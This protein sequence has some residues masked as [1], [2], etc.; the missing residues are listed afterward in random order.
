M[1]QSSLI[2]SAARTTTPRPI[3]ARER[4]AGAQA[5]VLAAAQASL[6][7]SVPSALAVV[8]ETEGSVYA[9]QGTLA[10]FGAGQQTGWISGGCLEPALLACAEQAM[11]TDTLQLL[12]IDNLDD[13]A[14][15]SGGSTGCRGRQVVAIF[16]L[17]A[18]PFMDA[19][20]TTWRKQGVSL[21]LTVTTSGLVHMACGNYVSQQVLFPVLPDTLHT[22]SR[23][24]V[25]IPT[26]PRV[27]LLG[28]GPEAV[29]LLRMLQELG[30][31]C[32]CREPRATWRGRSNML[33]L[34]HSPAVSEL[35]A[36]FSPDA[37][38]LMHHSFELDLESLQA[39]AKTPS[40]F[41]G[42]LGPVRRRD[43]L[44][45]FITPALLPGLL[46]RLR[47]PVGLPLG[48]VGPAGIALSVC[49]ELEAWRSGK[50]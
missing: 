39:V 12:E 16:P 13:A 44:L 7:E 42:V 14:M 37:V 36:D 17:S 49:A 33:T 10:L 21:E 18:V 11:A 26:A 29:Y 3:Q 15:F 47:A 5:A 20:I 48:S 6:F 41:V 25:R 46:P 32:R 19:A 28:A 27:L 1:S 50:R 38:V 22:R 35:L 9:R 2:A 24:H 45:K 23:W 30:W 43:D 40:P 8:V 31:H 34:E 4:S